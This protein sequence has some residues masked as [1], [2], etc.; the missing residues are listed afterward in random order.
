MSTRGLLVGAVLL[1]V[2]AGAVYWS[3]RTKT[4]EESKDSSASKLVSIKDEDLSRL[5][6][7]RLGAEPVVVERGKNN[8]WQM[9]SPE[10]LRL[11][12]DAVSSLVTSFTGLTQDRVIDEKPTDLSAFG[13][14]T[15]SIEVTATAKN[16]TKQTLLIGDD[17]PTGSGVYAKLDNQPRVFTLSTGTKSSFDK[18]ARDLRDKRLLTF[19]SEKLTRVELNSKGTAIEFGKNNQNEWSIV[20]PRPLR[21]DNYGVDELVRKL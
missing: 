4:A 13:L 1:A 18:T 9:K 20:K 2:L 3:E 14:G 16:G 17:T 12:Q 5:E 11:D 10:P 8:Q 6:I 15:P 7:R 19:D 21:A